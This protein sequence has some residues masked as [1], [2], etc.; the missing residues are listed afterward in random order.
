MGLKTT[1]TIVEELK[2]VKHMI[3]IQN[4]G[5]PLTINNLKL[6]VGQI[7]QGRLTPFKDG[8]QGK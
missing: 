2:L 3:N 4:L 8:V 1:L 5:Y 7:C 6:K